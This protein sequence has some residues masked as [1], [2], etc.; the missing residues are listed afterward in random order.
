M[1]SVLETR[2]LFAQPLEHTFQPPGLTLSLGSMMPQPLRQGRTVFDAVG[3]RAHIERA[4]LSMACAFLRP[5]TI[6]AWSPHDVTLS[7]SFGNCL[8]IS[9]RVFAAPLGST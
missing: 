7:Y 4:C 2:G 8:S 5:V 1:C 3:P 6:V 9:A